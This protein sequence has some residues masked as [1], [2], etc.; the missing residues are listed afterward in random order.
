MLKCCTKISTGFNFK[1]KLFFPFS[2]NL[3]IS[4]KNNFIDV[5]SPG[6]CSLLEITG[7][8]EN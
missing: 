7:K 3:L 1:K 2:P 8:Y 4:I 6:T 5:G